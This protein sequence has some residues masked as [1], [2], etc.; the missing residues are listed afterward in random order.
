MSQCSVPPSQANCASLH[1]LKYRHGCGSQPS[2]TQTDERLPLQLVPFVLGHDESLVIA[3]RRYVV[4]HPMYEQTSALDV[5]RRRE[6]KRL[7]SCRAYLDYTGASLYPESLIRYHADILNKNVFGNP[8]STSPRSDFGFHV[9]CVRVT[10]STAN[11][12]SMLTSEYTQAARDAVLNFFSGDPSEYDV[13]FAANCTTALRLVGESYPFIPKTSRL[14]LPVDAHNSVNGLREFATSAGI[15]V[16]YISMEQ[17]TD[18][19]AALDNDGGLFVMTGQSNLSGLKSDLNLI[20]EA[21]RKGYDTLLDAAALAPTTPFSL[22]ALGNN[23]DA[24][25]VSLYK[26]IGYPTGVGC[27]VARKTF[28]A[29][30]RKQWFSGGTVV[31]VQVMLASLLD[32]CPIYPIDTTFSGSWQRSTTSGWSRALGGWNYQFFVVSV[33]RMS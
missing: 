14:V 20:G 29:K 13:V 12:S 19:F 25:A 7:K 16:Q 27:L 4:A 1:A 6:F 22:R 5:L 11:Y 9:V 28:L 8:H 23:V 26:M 32:G 33:A 15:P 24:I 21:K 30:L 3:Q 2:A 31:I 17:Y 10:Q 18:Q